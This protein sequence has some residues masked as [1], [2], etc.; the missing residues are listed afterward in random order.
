MFATDE[1]EAFSLLTENSRWRAQDIKMVGA[2]DGQTYAKIINES[3][4]T[5]VD[6]TEKVAE[7]KKTLNKYIGGH[8]KLR[9]EQFAEE[10]DPRV[11]RAKELIDATQEKIAPLE[12]ELKDIKK[13]IVQKAFDA[14]L[15]KA[16]GNMERPRDFSVIGRTD[17]NPQ[18]KQFMENF[19]QSKRVI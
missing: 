8:D 10:D 9:F 7:L 19:K 16:R 15:E 2:S 18:N 14:E 6:L 13:N 12:D 11:V 17:N 4:Q 1:K 5:T 3:K